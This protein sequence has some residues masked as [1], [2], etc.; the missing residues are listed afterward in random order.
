MLH[1]QPS[2]QSQTPAQF[3]RCLTEV[4]ILEPGSGM[5]QAKSSK[6]APLEMCLLTFTCLGHIIW[7]R[8]QIRQDALG[9]NVVAILGH[10]KAWRGSP[11]QRPFTSIDTW[12]CPK[13]ICNW[14]C[15][16]LKDHRFGEMNEWHAVFFFLSEMINRLGE[17][18][19]LLFDCAC[20]LYITQ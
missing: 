11:G 13:R 5:S 14:H 18:W 4:N 17:R 15:C 9:Q 7:R 19:R 3:S 1:R 10:Y 16:V 12:C 20:R 8:L 6:V 2:L